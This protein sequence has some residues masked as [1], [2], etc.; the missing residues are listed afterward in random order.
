MRRLVAPIVFCALLAVSCGSTQDGY[1]WYSTTQRT[2]LYLYP[3]A[4]GPSTLYSFSATSGSGG[5]LA[6]PVT[7]HVDGTAVTVSLSGAFGFKTDLI[8]QVEDGSLVLE[9]GGQNQLPSQITMQPASFDQFNQE[10]S[11]LE[12]AGSSSLPSQNQPGTSA[13][14]GGQTRT[15]I[16]YPNNFS[17]DQTV[18]GYCWEGSFSSTRDDA[19]RCMASNTIYDPCFTY[20]STAVA[21]PDLTEGPQRGTVIDLSQPLPQGGTDAPGSA[22]L[23]AFKLTNGDT[24]GLLT[25]MG[26]GLADYPYGCNGQADFACT[27]PGPPVDGT[28]EVTCGA[29]D[30]NG[31]VTSLRSFTVAVIYK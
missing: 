26:P 21:C 16:Y 14:S 8:G 25:G 28:V 7:L 29:N 1:L 15:V 18:Q 19:Y 30:Q 12:S 31:G 17:A 6:L 9:V 20:G 13:G 2:L 5:S 24:C 23:W 27:N 10:L 22:G 11:Q 3:F 4:S